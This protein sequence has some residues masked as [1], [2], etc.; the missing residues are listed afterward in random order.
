MKIR[1]ESEWEADDI[2]E[3][4]QRND[5]E[6]DV[7]LREELFE[8]SS[9]EFLTRP[10]FCNSIVVQKHLNAV[11]L[12]Y[13]IPDTYE[14]KFRHLFKRKITKCSFGELK[15]QSFPYFIKPVGND[16]I[17][18]GTVVKCAQ[19]LDELW[20]FHNVGYPDKLEYYVSEVVEFSSE[21]R[22]FI[23]NGKVYA[24][25]HQSGGY[26]SMSGGI[27]C[28]LEN[29]ILQIAKNDFYAVD[30]GYTLDLNRWSIVEINP[31]FSLDDFG[32][33]LALYMQYCVD[34]AQSISCRT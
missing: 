24:R 8:M 32:I 23:G 30:I 21:Y 29:E 22:L 3:F 5:I 9:T 7:V 14:E 6:C 27:L 16:K 12:S 10:F 2:I 26:L 11:G 18:D 13:L 1:L 20:E 4:C 17:F 34:F 19:D 31:P 28:L 33:D 25:G 15:A